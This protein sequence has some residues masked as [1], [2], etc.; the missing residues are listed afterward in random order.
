MGEWSVASAGY[1][2]AIAICAVA[3]VGRL[4]AIKGGA[5]RMDSGRYAGYNVAIAG[6][7][8]PLAKVMPGVLFTHSFSLS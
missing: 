2:P 1:G 4:R 7:H 3:T 5:G 8:S 6:G